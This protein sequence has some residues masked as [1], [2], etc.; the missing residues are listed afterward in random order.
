M[1][2]M[3]QS[4]NKIQNTRHSGLDPES[5]QDSRTVVKAKKILNQVQY[6]VETQD[7]K[8]RYDDI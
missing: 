6:D 8:V 3:K 7:I 2:Y 5:L 4:Y 1:I